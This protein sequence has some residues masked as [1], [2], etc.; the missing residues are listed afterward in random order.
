M[1]FKLWKFKWCELQYLE[2][3]G[4]H[5]KSYEKDLIYFLQNSDND[6][7]IAITIRY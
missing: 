7:I 5:D 2:L 1:R 6:H 3:N 4:N